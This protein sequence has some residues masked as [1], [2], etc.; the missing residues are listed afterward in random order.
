MPPRTGGSLTLLQE[1]LDKDAVFLA[2]SGFEGSAT[3]LDLINGAWFKKKIRM[4]FW[5]IPYSDIPEDKQIFL[6]EQW[7]EMQRVLA[8]HG[9]D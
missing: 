9:D 4:H 8:R 1:N 5:R 2:H 3:I 6:Y 7:D